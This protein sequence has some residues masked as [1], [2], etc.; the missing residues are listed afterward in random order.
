MRIDRRY[1]VVYGIIVAAAV[2]A[3]LV[4][5]IP[6]DPAYHRFAD[7]RACGVV[8]NC[9]NV[10]SNLA[11]VLVGGF[12]LWTVGNW[13]GEIRSA[14]RVF[15]WGVFLT[16]FGSAWY[17]WT[18]DDARLVWDRLPMT[19]AFMGLF[20]AVLIDQFQIKPWILPAL[21]ATGLASVGA[22]LA[23]DDLRLYG[24]VQFLPPV[25]MLLIFA[26]FPAG[27]IVRRR[28]YL[29]LGGYAA[30]KVAELRD[31]EIFLATSFFISGHTLKHLLAAVAAGCLL[32]PG[33]HTQAHP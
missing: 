7:S 12:G 24:L 21:V 26:L 31:A 23:F 19:L 3:L 20:A 14:F 28:I 5:P 1:L 11:F 10:L 4:G 16:G 27:R 33:K 13:P 30:A 9:L 22:W 15:W 18:P 29:A 8:P 2:G 25:V 17:H 6:Q 32:L